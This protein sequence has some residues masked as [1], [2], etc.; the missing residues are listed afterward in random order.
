MGSK[1]YWPLVF[2]SIWGRAED[3]Q[4]VQPVVPGLV[5]PA[6]KHPQPLHHLLLL[7]VWLQHRV[8]EEAEA[9]Q[10]FVE[11]AVWCLYV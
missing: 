3:V 1:L 10:D 7:A 4:L 8:P 2:L 9:A 11:E 6:V 5:Q